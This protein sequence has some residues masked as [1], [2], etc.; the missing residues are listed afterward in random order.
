MANMANITEPSNNQHIRL[1]GQ[2]IIP[3][4]KGW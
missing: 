2:V 3:L 4:R 1:A